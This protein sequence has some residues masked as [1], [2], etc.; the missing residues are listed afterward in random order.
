MV[1]ENNCACTAFNNKYKNGTAMY[2]TKKKRDVQ[3][4]AEE[5]TACVR[6]RKLKVK[7][8]IQFNVLSTTNFDKGFV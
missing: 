8:Q 1:I 4:L 6:K 5:Q 2:Y 3:Y 7:T